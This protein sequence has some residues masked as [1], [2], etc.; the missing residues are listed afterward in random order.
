MYI[1]TQ[2]SLPSFHRHGVAPILDR[3]QTVCG[4]ND[5]RIHADDGV[6]A[7]RDLYAADSESPATNRTGVPI[8]PPNY[9]PHAVQPRPYLAKLS[10]ERRLSLLHEIR[11]ETAKRGIRLTV[12]VIIGADRRREAF[13]HALAIDHRG[14]SASTPCRNH[15]AWQAYLRGLAEDVFR[16]C[17]VPIDGWLHMDEWEGPL[18]Q[19]FF[20][21]GNEASTICFCPHCLDRAAREG[22]D[23]RRA[24][25]GFKKLSDQIRETRETGKRWRDGGLTGLFALFLDYPELLAWQKMQQLIKEENPAM[26]SGIMKQCR[27]D[28]WLG[29]HII[30]TNS[31]NFIARASSDYARYAEFADYVNPL[32]YHSVSG[33]RFAHRVEKMQNAVFPEIPLESMHRAWL[34]LH[35]L[36][37]ELQPGW[38]GLYDAQLNAP[39]YVKEETAR[40]VESVAGRCKVYTNVGWENEALP[41]PK[42]R[43]SQ[44]YRAVMAAAEAGADGIFLSRQFASGLFVEGV[45]AAPAIDPRQESQGGTKIA[46]EGDVGPIGLEEYGRA[47]RDLGWIT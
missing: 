18:S 37:P 27:P 15:P 25:E 34:M 43:E 14:Q 29:C 8:H 20:Q 11:E 16:T 1:G 38:D 7:T 32:V 33:L 22:I 26:V 40:V 39:E 17:P 35:G 24:R 12:R 3:L 2:V 6:M 42:P 44:T 36:T 13:S 19:T 5:V 47:L 28:A 9:P 21:H 4:V 45:G 46:H 30:H 10:A 23:S 31:F 41:A